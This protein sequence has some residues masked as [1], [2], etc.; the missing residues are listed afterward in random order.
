MAEAKQL[1]VNASIIDGD[2]FYAHEVAMNFGPTQFVFDFKTVTPR[3]DP[4]ANP[5][6]HQATIV[7]RHNVV[8][9]E[10]FHA[11]QIL[12]VLGESIKKYEQQFGTIEKPKALVMMEKQM[13]GTKNTRDSS[14]NY[15]G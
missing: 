4:R 5:E 1:N 11:K 12:G 14:L 15:L 8:L 10:P 3:I 9:V 7:I 2:E 13:R 6:E